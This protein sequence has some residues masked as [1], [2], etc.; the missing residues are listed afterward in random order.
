MQQNIVSCNSSKD[1][2]IALHQNIKPY[3]LLLKSPVYKKSIF[4]VLVH[5]DYFNIKRIKKMSVLAFR[6]K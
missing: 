3:A 2:L 6:K 5:Y 4:V 1:L